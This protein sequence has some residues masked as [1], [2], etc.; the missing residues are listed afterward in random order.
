MAGDSLVRTLCL[1]CRESVNRVRMREGG[2]CSVLV[3]VLASPSTEPVIR[4]TVLRS[5][6]QFLYDNHSLNVL[7]SEGLIP[8]LVRLLQQ[9][10]EEADMK[11]SSQTSCLSSA[12]T[13][14]TAPSPV[15]TR[16]ISVEETESRPETVAVQSSPEDLN[17]SEPEETETEKPWPQKTRSRLKSFGLKRQ[18]QYLDL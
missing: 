2:G 15:E 17:L 8:C 5:L 9:V 18:H 4:D 1:Y 7:M 16:D 12:D 3:S 14:E 13:E 6:L 10:M 11:H